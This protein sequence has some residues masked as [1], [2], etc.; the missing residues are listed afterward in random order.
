[1]HVH[2]EQ[3]LTALMRLVNASIAALR[4]AA[5]SSNTSSA[6][7]QSSSENTSPNMSYTPGSSFSGE[8]KQ[9]PAEDAAKGVALNPGRST[10][11][12]SYSSNWQADSGSSSVGHGLSKSHQ[13]PT[14]TASSSS[15]GWG[16]KDSF[17]SSGDVYRR[18]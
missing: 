14:A 18:A 7:S 16:E 6:A 4:N 1:M 17:Y 10:G 11:S 9:F 15:S 2:R 8:T 3:D 12:S 5:N 13:N